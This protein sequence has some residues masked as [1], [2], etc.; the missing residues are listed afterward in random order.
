M[1]FLR[2]IHPICFKCLLSKSITMS[3]IGKIFVD[4]LIAILICAGIS[5]FVASIFSQ[6]LQWNYFIDFAI[7][8]VL[9]GYPLWIGN[10]LVGVAVRRLVPWEKNPVITLWACL[11]MGLLY[12]VLAIV[13]INYLFYSYKYQGAISV[14]RLFEVGFYTMLSELVI[15]F[16]IT[17]IMYL[18]VF[19]NEWRQVLVENEHVKQLA[20]KH[21]LEAIKSQVNPHFLFNSLN[22]LTSLVETNQQQAVKFI[23][24]LSEVYRYVLESRDKDLVSIDA[25]LKFANSFIFLQKMRFDEG[26]F[27]D[28]DLHDKR[29]QVV[30][31]AMQLLLEN[32][33]KHNVISKAQPLHIRIFDE[34]GYLVVQNNLQ[35]KPTLVGAGFGLNSITQRYRHFTQIPVLVE[36]N[37]GFFSV[38]IPKL[39]YG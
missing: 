11:F 37:T 1:K 5:I 33:I 7:Y 31:L 10:A 12:S 25:E 35:T 38:K 9:I 27:V 29:F 26:L 34:G 4:Q 22:V 15:S 3:K 2:I 8:G 16:I 19:F 23:K 21:E 28:I 32:A 6:E 14:E 24:Q 18:K 30:P 20:L 13:V 36:A 17:L 39:S